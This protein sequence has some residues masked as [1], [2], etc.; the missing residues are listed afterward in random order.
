MGPCLCGDP[1]CP[2][3]GPAQGNY[4][5][6]NCGTWSADGGCQDQAGCVAANKACDEAMAKELEEAQLIHKLELE[7]MALLDTLEKD[8][9]ERR[10]HSKSN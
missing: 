1:Y 8:E 7:R 6:P 9:N 2:S 3:C 10:R 5:C 4:K